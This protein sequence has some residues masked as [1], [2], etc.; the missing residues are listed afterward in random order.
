L[1]GV[2]IVEIFLESSL[3]N[4]SSLLGEKLDKCSRWGICFDLSSR[5]GIL[6]AILLSYS[7]FSSSSAHK[8]SFIELSIGLLG[9][10]IS[11]FLIISSLGSFSD[12]LSE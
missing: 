1:T 12:I 11:L 6:W 10:R 5:T 2:S 3:V 9:T 7:F 8:F 4:F